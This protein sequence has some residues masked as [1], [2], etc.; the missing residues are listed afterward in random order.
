MAKK[1]AASESTPNDSFGSVPNAV[2]RDHLHQRLLRGELPAK[3][4][5]KV[6]KDLLELLSDTEALKTHQEELRAFREFLDG[7]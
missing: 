6:H 7:H 3:E 1:K 4:A 5:A 2:K